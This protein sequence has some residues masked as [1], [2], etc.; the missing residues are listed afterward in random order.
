MSIHL[1]NGTIN[2]R[3]TGI[4]SGSDFYLI[5]PSNEKCEDRH[6]VQNRNVA[7][8]EQDTGQRDDFDMDF[9][10]LGLI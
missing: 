4:G 9:E 2:I 10:L 6:A 7:A 3:I 1:S 8:L 5:H